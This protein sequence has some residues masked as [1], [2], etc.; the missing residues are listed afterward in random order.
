MIKFCEKGFSGKTAILKNKVLVETITSNVPGDSKFLVNAIREQV[1]D[2]PSP[3]IGFPVGGIIRIY[4]SNELISPK[5]TAIVYSL[6]YVIYS[7]YLE[8]FVMQDHHVK[9]IINP[10]AAKMIKPTLPLPPLVTPL[11]KKPKISLK[12]GLLTWLKGSSTK[13]SDF[14]NVNS[15]ETSGIPIIKRVISYSNMAREHQLKRSHSSSDPSKDPDDPYRFTKLKRLIEYSLISSSPDCHFPY[16]VLLNRLEVEQDQLIEQKSALLEEIVQPMSILKPIMM[17]IRQS[18][19]MSSI[20]SSKKRRAQHYQDENQLAFLGSSPSNFNINNIALPQF[21]TAYSSLRIPQL[22]ADSRYGLDHLSLDTF[23]LEGF[24]NHQHIMIGFT[25]HPIGCPEKSCLGPILTR[26]DYFKFESP[27]QDMNEIIFPNLDQTLGQT[28]R[29]WCEQSRSSCQTHIEK[30]TQFIP[31]LL[32]E[33]P[34]PM[35]ERPNMQRRETSTSDITH[36]SSAQSSGTNYKLDSRRKCS[37]FHGCNQKLINHVFCITHGMGKINIYLDTPPKDYIEQEEDIIELWLTC[38]RCDASTPSK[39]MHPYTEAFSFGKYLELLFYSPRFSSPE[40]FPCSHIQ[41]QKSNLLR[42]FLHKKSG[43]T[44]KIMNEEMKSYEIRAPRFQIGGDIKEISSLKDPRLC[45]PT[46]HQWHKMAVRDVDTFFEAVSTHIN[47]LDRYIIAEGRRKIRD[48]ASDLSRQ[49]QIELMGLQNELKE[50]Q[51]R[52][53]ADQKALIDV[54]SDTHLNELNDFRRFFA[55]QSDSLLGYLSEWQNSN[56]VELADECG[57][58]SP[59]YISSTM[60]HCFPGSSILV[61]ENEPSSIIAYTLSS[62]EYL[63]EVYGKDAVSLNKNENEIVNHITSSKN[64][65]VA[66]LSSTLN[67]ES[68]ISNISNSSTVKKPQVLDGYY[69]SIERKYLSQTVGAGTETASFRTMI[70]EVCKSSVSEV[71]AQ[72]SR[73]M[74]DLKAKWFFQYPWIKRQEEPKLEL[75][76]I[77]RELSERTIKPLSALDT[78]QHHLYQNGQQFTTREFKMESYFYEPQTIKEEKD[79]SPHIKHKYVHN[80]VEFTCIVYYAKE[81]EILR[82]K[83]DINLIIIESLSRCR[84]WTA[85]GGKSK[86]QFYKTE[87]DRFLV[88]EMMNAW[89]IAEKDAFLKFAPKYFDYMNKTDKGPSLMAKIFGFF[90]I[91]MKSAVDKNSVLNIDVLVM[92]HLFYNRNVIKRFDFKG[93]QERHVEEYRKQQKDS[94][95]WDG[96]WLDECRM[97]LLVN[98]QSKAMMQAAILNDTRFLSKCNIMDYSLLVGVDKEKYEMTVGIVDFIGT[99][100]WYKK[101]E[102]RSKSTLSRREVTI[103]PPEQYKERFIREISD[104]FIAVPGKFDLTQQA[105][106]MPSL[107]TVG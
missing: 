41:T 72:R 65:S 35:T 82:K 31:G 71:Q 52:L 79:I 73:R 58:V 28:I 18:S 37:V 3:T 77:K 106:M 21:I 53:N 16:P 48:L 42:C 51:K 98:E 10:K 34:A 11:E 1:K 56:C 70:V 45:L 85:S 93:I 59:D 44:V 17:N 69:S 103:I 14:T 84:H 83:C 74:D 57:W 55:L 54:L 99:Y 96:D 12:T 76:D 25:C 104:Y 101:L 27:A 86:S 24:K 19:I 78:E 80:G 91:R 2:D 9:L 7:L 40:H 62:N 61:R 38:N 32:V 87:D 67:T 100:T 8:T 66:T 68:Q 102:S 75:G 47:L 63:Q 64:E 60:V 88:K 6:V 92:E 13:K 30:Q 39:I 5:L 43:I 97:E 94:T 26:I 46:I 36:S 107:L 4:G 15:S 22:L 90:T 20:A 23:T 50:M 49:Y 89:N 105:Q 95:L 29:H 33:T 81:F